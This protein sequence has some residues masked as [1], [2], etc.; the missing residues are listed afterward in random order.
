MPCT[1]PFSRGTNC[2]HCCPPP[3]CDGDK[4]RLTYLASS[5][6]QSS[7]SS[8]VPCCSEIIPTT[9]TVQFYERYV[10][11]CIS[12]DPGSSEIIYNAIEDY[13]EGDVTTCLDDL[14]VRLRCNNGQFQVQVAEDCTYLTFFDWRDVTCYNC[15]PFIAVLDDVSFGSNCGCASCVFNG[16]KMVISA[17][18][19]SEISTCAGDCDCTSCLA[20]SCA[21]DCT[22]C[23][24]IPTRWYFR[25]TGLT[26][27]PCAGCVDLNDIDIILVKNS[28]CGFVSTQ[29][30]DIFFCSSIFLTM[31]YNSGVSRW[32]ILFLTSA[33]YELPAASFN[34]LG[35]NIFTLTSVTGQCLGYPPTITIYPLEPLSGNCYS[36]TECPICETGAATSWS[37]T[38]SGITDNSCSLCDENYNGTFILSYITGT[39]GVGCY[40]GLEQTVTDACSPTQPFYKFYFR[41]EYVGIFLTAET[42]TGEFYRWGYT[43]PAAINCFQTSYT[44]PFFSA[45]GTVCS[46]MPASVTL[47]ATSTIVPSTGVTSGTAPPIYTVNMPFGVTNNTCL[48]C[49]SDYIG[50]FTMFAGNGCDWDA[51]ETN[52]CGIGPEPRYKLRNN[53]NWLLE[54][55]NNPA[56]SDPLATYQ[57]DVSDWNCVANN[58]VT[59]IEDTAACNNLPTTLTVKPPIGDFGVCT[60]ACTFPLAKSLTAVFAGT[61]CPCIDAQNLIINYNSTTEKWEG[62]KLLVGCGSRTITIKMWV[63]TGATNC[64]N[65]RLDVAWSDNCNAA[66]T[67]SPVSCVCAGGFGA[68]FNQTAN[69]ICGCNVSGSYSITI[70]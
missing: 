49:A 20:N 39:A 44:L 3:R 21:V 1:G 63:V 2:C 17:S 59:K 29:P 31:N 51:L 69:N 35:P 54:I 70:Y 68:E 16:A 27:N 58:T 64:N 62:S 13:W 8:S 57:E 67:L 37:I 50:N 36:F 30:F 33:L 45:T 24:K 7:S 26:P 66:T 46:N 43:L 12:L 11:S 32:Q 53:A 38:L 15:N 9:L 42:S 10:G 55:A 18:G 52:I 48:S 60:S 65:L 25:I 40:W 61:N 41:L 23:A 14:T 4:V 34:C 5:T 22:Q 19:T 47:T 28:I 56:T 6:Q